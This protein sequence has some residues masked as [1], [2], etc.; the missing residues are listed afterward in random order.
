M[1]H[2]FREFII[3]SRKMGEVIDIKN[4]VSRDYEAAAI[5][6]KLDGGPIVFFHNL[7]GY[8]A[9]G[10]VVSTRERLYRSIE[11]D[12]ENYHKKLSNAMDSPIPPEVVGKPNELS[13]RNI[14]L[15]DLPVLKH[16]KEDVGYYI[17]SGIVTAKSVKH[18]FF[19]SSIHRFLILDEKRMAIRVV[20]RHLYTMIN[21]AKEKNQRLPISV[22]IGVHPAVMIAAGSSPPYGV[23]HFG[24]ANKLL[25]G[26]LKVFELP[27]GSRAPVDSEIVIEGYIDPIEVVDE[28]PFTDL[29]GTPD[30]VRKQPVVYVTSIYTKN[31]PWYYALVP[32]GRDHM[33]FMGFSKEAQI[34][35]YIEK[36]VPSVKKVRLTEGGC[37]WLICVASITK[38]REG[39]GKNVLMACFAAH[40]SLKIAIV[41]DEDIDP[42][43]PK[44]VEWALATRLQPSTGTIIIPSVTVSSLDPSSNQGQSIG[45]KLG[46]DVTRT[47]LKPKEKFMRSTI[48]INDEYINKLIGDA[49]ASYQ[50]RGEHT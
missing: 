38:I 7:D 37:G 41:V 6:R 50:R 43:D 18:G 9:V 16:F 31:D 49:I 19:N 20:P 22:A 36:I 13:L 30:I 40:P 14:T 15:K 48:P 26:M 23:D 17:T 8:K 3:E 10:N 33:F 11:V 28:G 47:L 24:V 25:N 4:H 46:L 42:D 5:L 2:T 21:E 29:T 27:N 44:Q 32:S 34:K 39:D 45:S 35:N 12:E 1:H